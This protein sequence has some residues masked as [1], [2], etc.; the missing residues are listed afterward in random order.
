MTYIEAEEASNQRA[1]EIV[2]DPDA[3]QG[4]CLLL[5]GPSGKNPAEYRF[6]VPK[7][8]K[9]FLLLRVKS[10]EPTSYHD[11]LYF[12]IDDGVFDRAQLRTAASWGWSLAAHNSKMSLICLQAFELAAGDHI[13]KL[14]PREPVHVDLV[15][16]T[17][18]P[19]LFD[20]DR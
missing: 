20:C 16:V 10:D 18:N 11:S 19:G 17:D 5:R 1:Y 12:G 8:G 6:S 7:T 13:V 4:R 2:T 14:A 15:A 3:S 9:Y